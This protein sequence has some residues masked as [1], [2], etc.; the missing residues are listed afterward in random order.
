MKASLATMAVGGLVV[1]GGLAVGDSP[2]P[3]QL[4]VVDQSDLQ[5]IPRPDDG[6]PVVKGAPGSREQIALFGGL[7]VTLGALGAVGSY[8]SAQAK[9]AKQRRDERTDPG[10]VASPA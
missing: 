10:A 3:T 6:P 4:Q 5:I 1:V 2:T 8:S 9:Q 7:F